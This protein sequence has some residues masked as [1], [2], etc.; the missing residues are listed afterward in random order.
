MR[1]YMKAVRKNLNPQTPSSTPSLTTDAILV[2]DDE[3]TIRKLVT[4]YLARCGYQVTAARSGREALDLCAHQ[5]FAI[6][7]TDLKMP[8][9][10]G[11]ELLE[12]LKVCAPTTDVI[13]TTG[14][15]TI[16]SA[17]RTLKG[18]AYDYI[19]KPFQLADV[20]NAVQRC[21]E[22]RRLQQDLDVERRLRTELQR[23]SLA[24]RHGQEQERRR[25]ARDLHDSVAQ[26]LVGVRM[27]LDFAE[28]ALEGVTP[29]RAQ[30]EQCRTVLSQA[31][32]E[33]REVA[34][35]LRPTVLD[36]I[37]LVS[38]L[39]DLTT[40]LARRSSVHILLQ[41]TSDLPPLS[42]L[43]E[44]A[45]YRIA[46]EALSNCLQHPQASQISVQLGVGQ[47]VVQLFISD[48]GCGMELR[49]EDTGQSGHGFD[50]PREERRGLGLWNMR[51]RAL[52][53]G[54]T[55]TLRSSPRR[56]VEIRVTVPLSLATENGQPHE[57]EASGSS[58]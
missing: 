16:E 36:D 42:A 28:A 38:A 40:T 17:I 22:R 52:E 25:I 21:L 32:Q 14:Y 37:G 19:L 53:I 7:L 57:H 48:N 8:T 34:W 20:E 23:F 45:L 54:G 56:G 13:V 49:S 51:E 10:G 46:Q 55:Y 15:P 2:V 6:V 24:V 11:E 33:V 39:Q 9:L 35:T 4:N 41:L 18:G 3:A 44:T 1:Y 43:V 26:L 12:H 47:G 30:I 27:H 58:R 29:A 5:T 50:P 31:L